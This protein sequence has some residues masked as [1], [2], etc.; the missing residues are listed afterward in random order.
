MSHSEAAVYGGLS[1]LTNSDIVELTAF[2]RLLHAH[3]ELS[4][5]EKQTAA[6]IGQALG[7]LSPNRIVTGLGGHGVAAVF[8]GAAPGPTV[9]F[10]SELDA[11][12]IEELTDVAHRSTVPGKGHL[13]G[14]DGHSTILLALG[15]LISRRRPARG[16][17]VLLF[18]PAEE[19]GSGAASVIADPKFTEIKPDW[20]FSLHNMPGVR[21]GDVLLDAGPVNCASRGLRMVFS[22]K[23]SHAS[24]PEAGL[25]PALSLARLIPEIVAAGPGGVV[26]LGFKQ[27]TVTHLTMGEPAFGIAPGAGEL[28][29]TLRALTDRDMQSLLAEVTQMAEAEARSAGL[30]LT[31]SHH[32][33][34]RACHNHPEA[35]ARFATA[36][37]AEAVSYDKAGLPMRASEDFGLYGG[38]AK[39][40]MIF[41][42]VGEDFPMLHNPDYDFPDALIPHGTA[43]FHRVLRDILG[44]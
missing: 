43:I 1:V 12:P 28:W 13:C 31:F 25:S 23:T 27:T 26:G 24:V 10:R 33:V 30:G 2:R 32:D 22:G 14:H 4:G 44:G 36:L 37:E 41:L 40:A 7:L 35:A 42:G 16:R 19:D 38:S 29:V 21:F 11:L 9:M 15:R 17:V 18:Q 3:P 8:E 5:H 34:F 20:A 6:A 39:S